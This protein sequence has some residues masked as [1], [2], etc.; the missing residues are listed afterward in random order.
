MIPCVFELADKDYQQRYYHGRSGLR[1]DGRTRHVHEDYYDAVFDERSSGAV[2]SEAALPCGWGAL[3]A[4]AMK[5]LLVRQSP[6]GAV[7]TDIASE[8]ALDAQ[9]DNP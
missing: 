4:T 9:R 1:L 7:S 3:G 6:D 8:D 5:L 2:A